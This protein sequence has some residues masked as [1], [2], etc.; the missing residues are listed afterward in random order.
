MHCSLSS[1]GPSCEYPQAGLGTREM[2]SLGTDI[3][4]NSWVGTR[5]SLVRGCRGVKCWGPGTVFQGQ[6]KPTGTACCSSPHSPHYS[7][8]GRVTDT[9]VYKDVAEYEKV[10]ALRCWCGGRRG[11]HRRWERLGAPTGHFKG[12]QEGA[13]LCLQGST[14]SPSTPRHRRSLE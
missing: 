1:S 2:W 3:C 4:T 12:G 8:L 11:T 13:H 7:I 6:R 14:P 9:D 10:K 5:M